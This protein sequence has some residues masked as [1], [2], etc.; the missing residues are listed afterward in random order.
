VPPPPVDNSFAAQPPLPL[1][2]PPPATPQATGAPLDAAAAYGL[3]QQLLATMAPPG[4][5]A[6]APAAFTPSPQSNAAA[7]LAALLAS[8]GYHQGGQAPGTPAAVTGPSP[9]TPGMS[10][11]GRSRG[12]VPICAMCEVATATL[13]CLHCRELYCNTCNVTLHGQGRFK[14]HTV[15][16]L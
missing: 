5:P 16:R 15:P 6:P 11:A 8:A 3:L 7:G 9:R 10:A 14:Q 12:G 1:S 4:T 2:P 13:Q